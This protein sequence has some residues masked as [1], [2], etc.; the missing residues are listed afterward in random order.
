MTLNL[1]WL[2]FLDEVEDLV[3][4]ISVT[5]VKVEAWCC[6]SA[7]DE[8]TGRGCITLDSILSGALVSVFEKHGE[9]KSVSN[10]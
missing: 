7:V 4:S 3:K 10:G 9:L 2:T 8:V 5:L 6:A 1:L